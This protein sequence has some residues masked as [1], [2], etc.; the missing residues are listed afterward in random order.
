MKGKWIV[1][2]MAFV[3]VM[4]TGLM[5]VGCKNESEEAYDTNDWLIEDGIVKRYLGTASDVKVPKGVKAVG[6]S[7]FFQRKSLKSV[8]IPEGVTWIGLS[9]FV[10]C[11]NLISVEIPDSVELIGNSAFSGCKSLRSVFIPS[12]IR[13]I[14]GDTFYGCKSLTDVVIPEG[15]G[16]IGDSAF[17]GCESLT[18]VSIPSSLTRIENRAF[19]GC[20]N[21][22]SVRYGG[23]I[24]QWCTMQPWDSLFGLRGAEHVI[25]DG[26]DLKTMTSLVIPMGVR[27]IVSYAFYD[28][29][30][31]TSVSIPGSVTSINVNAFSG[32]ESLT[33]VRYDG[34]IAQW[35]EIIGDLGQLMW[36]AK[37]VIV[38]GVDLKSMNNLVIPAGVK[39]IADYA[40]YKCEGLTNVDIPESVSSI[41]SSTFRQCKN[42]TSVHY[43]GTMSNWNAIEKGYGFGLGVTTVC[44]DGTI[45]Y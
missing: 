23:T 42:L 15:V 1:T 40:F 24:A 35:C 8:E 25:I 9:A 12:S 19:S 10:G 22:T 33:D 5:L 21:L 20:K 41:G 17:A 39:E 18:S 2:L 28:C 26:I 3:V 7:A 36:N 38:G 37:H 14:N 4:A 30:N 43:N 16:A 27:F 31:I 45:N 44:S 6:N 11:E 29:K 13:G 34:T 32:C